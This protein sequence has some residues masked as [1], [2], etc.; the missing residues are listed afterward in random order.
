MSGPQQHI[1]EKPFRENQQGSAILWGVVVQGGQVPALGGI[2]L[3]GGCSGK[4]KTR[5]P[6]IREY[7]AQST[8]QVSGRELDVWREDPEGPSALARLPHQAPP[9]IQLPSALFAPQSAVCPKRRFRVTLECSR[10]A[11]NPSPR[12]GVY[13]KYICVGPPAAGAETRAR[14][15]M[16]MWL[17]KKNIYKMAFPNV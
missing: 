2:F 15:H 10:E 6:G 1:L 3:L 14:G 7:R 13:I 8:E 9:G 16:G 12:P 11:G 5:L 4:T 17:W